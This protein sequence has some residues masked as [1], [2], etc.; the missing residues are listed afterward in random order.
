MLNRFEEKMGEGGITKGT[1]QELGCLS[2]SG[3][4][5][6]GLRPAS[7]R[8]LPSTWRHCHSGLWGC[9]VIVQWN[10]RYST[11]VQTE[12]LHAD[13]PHPIKGNK[14]LLLSSHPPVFHHCLP[15]TVPDRE[16]A[17]AM[18]SGIHASYVLYLYNGVE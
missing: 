11:E 2:K 18:G 14:Q 3:H 8:S 1:Q 16:L 6:P 9:S 7:L 4:Y 5:Y 10:P 17:L 13:V 12:M 15:L